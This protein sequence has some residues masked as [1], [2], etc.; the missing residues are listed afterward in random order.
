MS[1]ALRMAAVALCLVLAACG[2]KGTL[3]PKPMAEMHDAL[4]QADD[5]PPVFGSNVPDLSMDSSDPSSV[6]WIV[7]LRGSEVMRFV[8]RLQPEGN[9]STRMVLDLVGVTSGSNGDVAKRLQDHPELKRLYLVAMTEEIDST[10]DKRAYDMSK[11]YPA[12]IAATA[13]NVGSISQQMEAAA[14]ADHKRDE[15]NIRKAYADEAAGN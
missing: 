1:N 2:S 4:A 10:L 9:A 3:Y 12:L 5:L 6:A 7:N 15:D 13:A 8:A 14:A 11:T